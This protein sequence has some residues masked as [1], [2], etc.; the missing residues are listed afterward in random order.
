[1]AGIRIGINGMNLGDAYIAHLK[2][3]FSEIGVTAEGSSGLALSMDA[4]LG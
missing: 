1:M 4:Q 3:H 2:W